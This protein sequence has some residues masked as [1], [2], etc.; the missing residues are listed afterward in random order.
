MAMKVKTLG[1]FDYV[2]YDDKSKQLQ[3]F[4]KTEFSYVEKSIEQNFKDSRYKSLAITK[5]EEAYMYIGKAI[6]D[7]QFERNG[8]AELQ[9]ERGDS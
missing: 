9:E 1:R 6:R 4:F 7:E 8:T 3:S 2:A 5:L